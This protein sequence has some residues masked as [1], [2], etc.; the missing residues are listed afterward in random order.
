MFL[1]AKNESRLKTLRSDFPSGD[2]SG[3]RVLLRLDLNLP[4]K[5][6][7]SVEQNGEWRIVA[8]LP[9][10]KYLIAQDAKVII[11]SHLGRPRG[12]V[13]ETLRLSSVQKKLFEM[14][15]VSA[16]RIPDCLDKETEKAI[17]EMKNGEIMM[18]ENLRFHAG[19]EK[20]DKE[21]A[22]HLAALG[23][24]YVND[25]FGD[26][27]REHASIVGITKFLPS[28]AGFLMEK[29]YESLEYAFL[30]ARPSVAII[31]GAKLETK[32]PVVYA[33][34]KIYNYILVGGMIANE[35]INTSLS[36]TID[37]NVILPIND[38]LAKQKYFDIGTNSVR[39]FSVFID[40]AKTII[41]NGPMGKF[42]EDEFSEGT[43]GIIKA[44]KNAY[45]KNGVRIII[46]GG[47]TIAAIQRFAPE[48]FKYKDGFD[49]LAAGRMYISTGGGAM[50]EFLSGK[51]LPGIEALKK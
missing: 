44:I 33:L 26:S 30:P 9:T 16:N 4:I 20:N 29:E 18:L 48:F 2:L 21:F 47:E 49:K 41:W 28:Y 15:G 50:L 6:D 32:L 36:K 5:K 45:K 43:I 27:H 38:G 37:P 31:G 11:L 8:A 22:R 7:G 12:K 24:I 25:A 34:S 1:F 19:E 14:L 17:A 51:K 40:K 10:V 46:G 3:K 35:I 42:E 13:V 23:D 39:E